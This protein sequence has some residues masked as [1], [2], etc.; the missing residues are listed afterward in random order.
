MT[1]GDGVSDIDLDELVAFHQRDGASCH[2]HR[3]SP[4]GPLRQAHDRRRPR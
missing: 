1:Y 4:P 2:D 3:G